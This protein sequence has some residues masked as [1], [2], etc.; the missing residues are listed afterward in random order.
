MV[1]RDGDRRLTS[2]MTATDGMRRAVAKA[3]GRGADPAARAMSARRTPSAAA[4]LEAAASNSP[5]TPPG[6]AQAGETCTSGLVRLMWASD[7]LRADWGPKVNAGT[8]VSHGTD[9][10][11]TRDPQLSGVVQRGERLRPELRGDRRAVQL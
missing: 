9:E 8:E 7:I 4:R 3:G 1:P 10:A 6:G 5:R 2:A 11:A